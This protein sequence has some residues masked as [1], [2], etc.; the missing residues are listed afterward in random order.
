M[1]RVFVSGC[2]DLLHAGHLAFLEEAAREGDELFVSV[3]SDA[4]VAALKRPPV[5][6]EHDRWRMVSALGVVTHAFISRGSP[7]WKD[8]LSYVRTLRPDV[9]VIA[10]DDPWL[11]EKQAVAAELS[12]RVVLNYRPEA[13]LSTTRLIEQIQNRASR[14]HELGYHGPCSRPLT[15]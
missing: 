13:G 11:A 14:P 10:A 3:A 5:W 8:C 1:T 6:N 12:I 2:F 9:W 7:D 15:P 4:T